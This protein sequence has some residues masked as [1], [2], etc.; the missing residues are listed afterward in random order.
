MITESISTSLKEKEWYKI[1][2]GNWSL[3]TC[4]HFIEEYTETL[5]LEQIRF[6]KNCVIVYRD[7]ACSG[8]IPIEEKDDFTAHIAGI[9]SADHSKI[10]TLIDS[11][12]KSSDMMGVYTKTR[13]GQKWNLESYNDFWKRIDAHYVLH[14]INKWV[15]ESLGP[16]VLEKYLHG[17]QE[18]RLHGEPVF[19]WVE[20]LIGEIAAQV[21][22]ETGISADLVLCSTKAEILAYWKGGNLADAATLAERKKYAA[23]LYFTGEKAFYVGDDARVI[24]EGM[25]PK[26]KQVDQNTLKGT[27]A[28][29]GKARGVV[30]IILDPRKGDHFKDGDILVA[31][32][33]RPEYLALMQKAGAFVTDSGGI[34]SHAAIVARELKKPCVIGTQVATKKLKEGDVVEVDAEKGLV[35]IIK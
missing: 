5:E 1:W 32:M 12:I 15:V 17:L 21:S 25:V 33:T 9:Y 16:E 24:E 20:D 29:P 31:G 11:F 3:L 8:F 26:Q 35:T 6:A 14:I 22:A 4:T 28:Y 7:G 2:A 27:T 30:R 18:A 34:L 23:T 19:K 10:S 13:S